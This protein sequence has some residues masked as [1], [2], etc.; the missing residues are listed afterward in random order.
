M[1]DDAA[2][3]N[4]DDLLYYQFVYSLT[5]LGTPLCQWYAIILSSDLL[6]AEVF[7]EEL[8]AVRMW[9]LAAAWKLLSIRYIT[10]LCPLCRTGKGSPVVRSIGPGNVTADS[11][12]TVASLLNNPARTPRARNAYC[13][14]VFVN[15]PFN[16]QMLP[17]VGRPIQV[18]L[19]DD[20]AGMC[21]QRSCMKHDLVLCRQHHKAITG[22]GASGGGHWDALLH[23]CT[24]KL[25]SRLCSLLASCY[26]SAKLEALYSL[27]CMPPGCL[28]ACMAGLQQFFSA[29]LFLCLLQERDYQ[30]LFSPRGR[31]CHTA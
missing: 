3:R 18:P 15:R 22:A 17:E 19:S 28:R 26:I 6:A 24:L 14:G 30:K 4:F 21:H 5:D 23:R 16:A 25:H 8:L 12:L 31:Y 2:Y 20:H 1:P 10:M 7:P 29:S 27:S 11:N 13:Q 9:N